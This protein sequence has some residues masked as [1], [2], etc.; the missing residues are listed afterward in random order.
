MLDQWKEPEITL[1]S[2][3][4]APQRNIADGFMAEL[5]PP[6]EQRKGLKNA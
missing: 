3:K 6:R 4:Q 2:R 1:G 5:E